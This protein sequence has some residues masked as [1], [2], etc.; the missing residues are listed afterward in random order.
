MS[1]NVHGL[2][3]RMYSYVYHTLCT[4]Y[5]RCNIRKDFIVHVSIFQNAR[6][7]IFFFPKK[8]LNNRQYK[9][10]KTREIIRKIRYFELGNTHRVNNVFVRGFIYDV[11]QKTGIRIVVTLYVRPSAKIV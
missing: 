10:M 9:Y 7:N 2:C 1:M 6:G 5:F 11:L 3:V 8:S 4:I